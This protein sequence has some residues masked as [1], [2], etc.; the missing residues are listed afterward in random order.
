[1]PPPL[2]KALLQTTSFLLFLCCLSIDEEAAALLQW[3][4]TLAA[5]RRRWCHGNHPTPTTAWYGS[6]ATQAPKVIGLSLRS[7][8][9]QGPLPSNFEALGALETLVI[10]SANITGPIPKAIG[11][12]QELTFLDLSNNQI[13]G[14]IPVELFRLTKLESLDLS[15]NSLE[16]SIPPD[17]GNLSRLSVTLL[18]DNYHRRDPKVA[19]RKLKAT[20]FSRRR[21]PKPQRNVAAGDW[22][23]QQ[24]C[25]A[26]P[27]RNW[28]LWHSSVYNWIVE[29]NRDSCH[30]HIALGGF[31]SR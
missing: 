12:Y 1:M 14:E 11:G 6:S 5:P 31:D 4:K 27:C 17:V 13:F 16:G 7:V 26:R 2:S 25:N 21:E 15:S 30:L 8:D 24:S 9:L 18:Y 10:T 20:S 23:L 22:E 19:S 29:E 3:K 28:D